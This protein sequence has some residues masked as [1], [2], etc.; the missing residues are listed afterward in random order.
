V[1]VRTRWRDARAVAGVQ[2]GSFALG[3]GGVEV[4]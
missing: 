4:R 2:V 1:G 3:P